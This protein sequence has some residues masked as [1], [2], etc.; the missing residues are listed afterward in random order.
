MQVWA[1]RQVM[2]VEHVTRV[3][4][5]TISTFKLSPFKTHAPLWEAGEEPLASEFALRAANAASARPSNHQRA[6]MY[7]FMRPLQIASVILLARC[8]WAMGA[9]PQATMLSV[10][11]FCGTMC[12]RGRG[13]GG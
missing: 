8:R 11:T 7:H 2:V 6:G 13:N 9:A 10:F 5:L 1:D 4:Y 3:L 12:I